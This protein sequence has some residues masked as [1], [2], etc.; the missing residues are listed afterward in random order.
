ML[1]WWPSYDGLKGCLF[2]ER[3]IFFSIFIFPR[4]RMNFDAAIYE[5]LR[6][7]LYFLLLLLFKVMLSPRCFRTPAFWGG[8][9]RRYLDATEICKANYFFNFIRERDFYNHLFTLWLMINHINHFLN[10]RK[11]A[12]ILIYHV[13]PK[14]FFIQLGQCNSMYFLIKKM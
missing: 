14:V 9:S 11:G 2:R 3:R 4:E 10:L 5:R 13:S 8:Y 1:F 7:L 12:I 6:K